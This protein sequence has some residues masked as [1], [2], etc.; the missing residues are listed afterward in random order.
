[1]NKAK[2]E[3]DMQTTTQNVTMKPLPQREETR[4]VQGHVG[5]TL[6]TAVEK[7]LEKRG[8]TIKEAINFGLKAFL[9][10]HNPEEAARLGIRS[11][12]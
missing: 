3:D 4:L 12:K 5:T 2:K 9:E 6:W 1:M 11:R 8:L 7:E 10:V